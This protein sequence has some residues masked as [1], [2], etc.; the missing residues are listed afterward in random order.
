MS[1]SKL[2]LLTFPR[3]ATGNL[4]LDVDSLTVLENAYDQD[5]GLKRQ[6]KEKILSTFKYIFK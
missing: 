6:S 5:T 2:S 3:V 4:I 1:D